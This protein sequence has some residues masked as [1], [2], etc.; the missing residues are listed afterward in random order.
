MKIA[1][2]AYCFL[3]S[4]VLMGL[5]V[6]AYSETQ[7]STPP[8]TF[9]EVKKMI[10]DMQLDIRYDTAYNF[11]GQKINGYLSPVCL[12]TKQAA[13]A[14][15]NVEAQLVPMGLTLKAYDCY[16]PQR[17]VNNFIEWASN[18]E[19]TKMKQAFY[20]NV[21]KTAL[22]AEGYIAERSGHSRG[23]T[24]DLTIV[25]LN[26]QVPNLSKVSLQD[27]CILEKNKRA[28]DNSLDFGSGYDCFSP[29]SHP[30]YAN[31]SAQAKANRLLLR[32]L[33][34]EA[35]FMP[36]DTEWWHFTLADEPYPNTY[37]NFPVDHIKH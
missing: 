26:S 32:T 5:S 30:D 23:S 35:G 31:I 1:S 9:V 33:M 29:V 34:M 17:A 12:L 11:V 14:L 25:P 19:D 15:K 3:T 24:I 18:V 7:I 2:V 22:F 16:R 27:S 21:D 20:P 10:P 8:E 37:F 36:L 4:S 6:S 28:P 13:E